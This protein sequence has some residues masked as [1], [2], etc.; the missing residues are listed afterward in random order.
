MRKDA[1]MQAKLY[2]A[3]KALNE[4]VKKMKENDTTVQVHEDRVPEAAP[5]ASRYT[6]SAR[7]C[8]YIKIGCVLVFDSVAAYALFTITKPFFF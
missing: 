1:E 6:T 2:A 5:N 8:R 7:V 3:V 4:K